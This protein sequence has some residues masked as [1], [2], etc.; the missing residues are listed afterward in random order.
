MLWFT[1][2]SLLVLWLFG[3]ISGIAFGGALHILLIGALG[4]A[5]LRISQE[6]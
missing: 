3:A 5:L 4:A 6:Q 2:W 1:F